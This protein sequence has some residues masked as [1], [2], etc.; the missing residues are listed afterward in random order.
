MKKT[1]N[2]RDYERKKAE[3]RAQNLPPKEYEK[4][5]RRLIAETKF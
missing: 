2:Y 1:I 4:A 5:I 3:I